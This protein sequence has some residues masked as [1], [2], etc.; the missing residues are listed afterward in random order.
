MRIIRRQRPHQL[1]STLAVALLLTSANC[2]RAGVLVTI[3]T[4]VGNMA[5]EL[6]DDDKPETVKNFIKYVD[7][8]LYGGTF[9][10]RW[11]SGFVIQAGGQYVTN[12][13]TTPA[14]MSVP[15]FGAII[16]EYSE[17]KTFSNTYGTLAM[18]RRGGETNSAS[19][20]WFI[21]LG[22]NS[23]LDSVDGGFTVF[24]MIVSGTNVLDAFL[25]TQSMAAAGMSWVEPNPFHADRLPV[26]TTNTLAKFNDLIYLD[27]RLLKAYI[28]NMPD[29]SRAITWESASNV[30]NAVEYNDDLL[31]TNWVELVQTNGTGGMMQA[32]DPNA[33]N[34]R[35]Y[36]IRV[37]Y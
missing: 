32:T 10:E 21:N 6:F 23:F 7:S 14:V 11:A 26:N 25:S 22:D 12:R 20:S 28:A 5:F 17:G 35:F 24:G 34:C 1:F 33:A 2:V 16:N 27:I 29:E 36:R 13:F 4:P 3:K 18:A 9:I 31:G 30:V 15:S 8:G 37:D 19:S